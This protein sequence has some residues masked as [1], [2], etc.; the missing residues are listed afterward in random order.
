[1]EFIST[2]SMAL[3]V[4]AT[5]L[6]ILLII[7]GV[8]TATVPPN[9]SIYGVL[10]CVAV[11]YTNGTNGNSLVA[12]QVVDTQPGVLNISTFNV[13]IGGING[14]NGNCA[15]DRLTQGE[16]TTCTVEVSA[17]VIM[18]KLYSGM[19]RISGSYC[20]AAPS[21]FG[22]AACPVTAPGQYA[23]S[24][25][26]GFTT[27]GAPSSTGIT[28]LLLP[29]FMLSSITV[30]EVPLDVAFNPSGTLAYVVNFDDG[31]VSVIDTTTGM[32]INTITAATSPEGIGAVGI[33]SVAFNP[34]GTF[35]YITDYATG[36]VIIIN[37]T[38]DT[39]VR[40]TT[41]ARGLSSIAFDPSG[42][43]AYVT[44]NLGTV[45]VIDPTTLKVLS[46]ITVGDD[47]EGV[48]FNP[49]GT[50]AYVANYGSGTVSV[51]DP[52]T[53]SVIDTITVGSNPEDVAFNPSGT[54][55]YVTNSGSGTVSV[56]NTTTGTVIN[57]TVVASYLTVGSSPNGVAF[58]PHSTFAYVADS[59]T[60]SVS[61]IN[62]A[63]GTVVDTIPVGI[64]PTSVAF[65]PSGTFA[66]V[67]NSGSD[68]VTI[69]T[70]I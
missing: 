11:S 68:T 38:T 33:T 70:K 5:V 43:F 8:P 7:A 44:G 59:Q 57:T 48:A 22:N 46:T 65:N 6:S 53:G 50:L 52:S 18:N 35:A 23:Y 3:L 40:T 10:R 24:F 42:T 1:M 58:N 36:K 13:I 47:P 45:S 37:T 16:N 64:T 54:L 15:S 60:D 49:S 56:I 12:I 39:V 63:T 61:V 9:C 66:Y 2:Y 20:T 62:T 17:N 69:I 28:A 4:I 21:S 51:I 41:V 34:S 31:T 25:V 26:G 67:V 55:A 30:G 27:S 29:P 19:I 14:I 32:V